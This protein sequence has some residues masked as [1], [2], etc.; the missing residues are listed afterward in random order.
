MEG[1]AAVVV[2]EMEGVLREEV[3]VGE[4]TRAS[5]ALSQIVLTMLPSVASGAFV[6]QPRCQMEIPMLG[7]VH[8]DLIVLIGLQTA[9]SLDIVK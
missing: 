2:E 8:Q 7:N 9:Q 5:V 6:K 3:E 1:E 4:V